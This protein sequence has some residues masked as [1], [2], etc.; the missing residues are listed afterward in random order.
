[1]SM[2]IQETMTGVANIPSS[3]MWSVR[4]G[5]KENGEKSPDQAEGDIDDAKKYLKKEYIRRCSQ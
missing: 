4:R 2:R 3:A 1:M 5:R